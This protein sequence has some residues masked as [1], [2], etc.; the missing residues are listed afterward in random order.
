MIFYMLLYMVWFHILET[1]RRDHFY[2]VEMPIDR[3]IPFVEAFVVPYF[4]WFVYVAAWCITLYY[5]DRDAYDRLSTYMMVGMTVFLLVSTFLPTKQ[6]LRLAAMPRNNVFTHMVESL[7]RTDTPTNVCPS[8]HVFNTVCILAMVLT[9]TSPC[10]K[11][12]A[13]RVGITIWSIFICL[14]TMFIKQHS[15]FDVVMAIL[16]MLIITVFIYCFG[17]VFRFRKW[18]AFAAHLEEE[19]VREKIRNIA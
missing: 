3:K 13:V 14:S 11:K 19:A 6:N 16:M 12:A 15:F 4:S 2:I 9:S 18:D 10:L 1:V 8:I 7:W 17:F 5:F